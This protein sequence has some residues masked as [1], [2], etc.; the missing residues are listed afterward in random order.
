MY[1]KKSGRRPR[2]GRD[3]NGMAGILGITLALY[4]ALM[5][6]LGARARRRTGTAGYFDGRHA[7]G[8]GA[9]FGLVTALWTSSAVAVEL[10]T[11]YRSGW[12][13]AWFGG[14]VALMSVAV[15]FW[16]PVIRRYGYLTN[17][18]LIGRGFGTAARR[19]AGGVI[20][21][22]FPVFALSNALVAAVFL[23][24]ALGWPL[25][26]GLAGVTALVLLYVQF[27]GLT[28]L[29][30]TQAV[31]LGLML[32]GLAAALWQAV[33][34]PLPV[35]PLPAAV[36][37]WQG[38]P[39]ATVL[40]W[41]TM[42]LLNGLA[43]QAEL[44]AL[45]AARRPAEARCAVVA[46]SLLLLGIVVASAWLGILVRQHWLPGPGGGLGAFARVM[47]TGSPW[48]VQVLVA[49]GV[50]AL[51]LTW[52]APLLFSGAVSLGRDVMRPAEAV[53]WTRWALVAEGVLLVGFGLLRPG[54]LAWWRVFGLT[55]RNAAVVT[56]TVA[57][58]LWPDL[59]RRW[60]LAAMTAAVGMG[61]GLN[62]VQGFSAG[63]TAL[64]PM[65][66]AAATGLGVLNLGR[67]W[68]DGRRLEGAV[69]GLLTA[70]AAWGALPAARALDAVP[71][72][73]PVVL[74]VP[75]LVTGGLWAF[76][77]AVLAQPLA[78]WEED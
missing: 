54:D 36:R 10:D 28:S 65:W 26:L 4:G 27:A 77:R 58:L 70:A 13:A 68:T 48:W 67:L 23:H 56:P 60:V 63:A 50:W 25:G 32:A 78:V 40:V 71:L 1:N 72:A 52:C 22:T 47:L 45:A 19:L 16:F 59:P 57:F 55:L 74:L 20:A 15:T 8:G 51:A 61:L 33:H 34:S 7:L 14:S 35:H 5:T 17:S 75:A 9:V 39:A 46:S 18:D 37:G 11:A 3:G 2:W 24:L 44:Q 21:L 64:S 42:N 62:L 43:A 38:V 30:A 69:T 76:R 49:A 31:N 66:P 6:W 12:G 73:G 53:R 29:A 41:L